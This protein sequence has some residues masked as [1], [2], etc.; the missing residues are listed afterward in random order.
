[1]MARTRA[2]PT[3]PDHSRWIRA[4]QLVRDALLA[5]IRAKWEQAAAGRGDRA[6]LSGLERA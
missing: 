3:W 2:R 4:Y 6:G 5:E 1:M